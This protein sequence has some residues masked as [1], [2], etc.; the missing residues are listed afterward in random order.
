[1][2]PINVLFLGTSSFSTYV[3]EF[4]LSHSRFQ[5]EAVLTKVDQISG[6]GMKLH[7][8]PVRVTAQKH[9]IPVQTLSSFKDQNA[10]KKFLKNFH[11]DV[12]IVVSYGLII[13]SYFLNWFSNRI[14]NIH[15][16][17]LPKWRGAAPIQHALLKG[18]QSTGVTLQEISPKLDAGDIIH[19]VSFPISHSMDATNIYQKM[20]ELACSLLSQYLPL[21]LDGQIQVTPQD[22]SLVTYAPKIQKSQLK[23]Q[24]TDTALKV[25][26]QI[27]AFTMD[28]GAF[29]LYNQKRIKIFKSELSMEHQGK[30]GQV[31]LYDKYKGLLV[32]CQT[33]AIYLQEVQLESKK[34]Q[35]VQTWMRGFAVEKGADFE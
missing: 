16:S 13:P 6:R 24:W 23:I 31:L 30:A 21:Y 28:G 17:L 2:K 15:T 4:L 5:V 32:A 12:V 27:R 18:D 26:N 7:P 3:L 34:R 14:V 11:I 10:I 20:T 9:S 8:S 1:M 19:Q 29:A 33:G 35:S 25:F 22:S